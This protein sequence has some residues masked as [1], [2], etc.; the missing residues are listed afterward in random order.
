MSQEDTDTLTANRIKNQDEF[1]SSLV[2]ITVRLQ[3]PLP[4]NH[5]PNMENN[6]HGNE[7]SAISNV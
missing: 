1:A 2:D 6:G 5:P 3:W 4:A 7:S